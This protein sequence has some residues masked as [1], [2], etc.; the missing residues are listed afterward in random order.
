MAS[1][2]T[3]LS[4][5]MSMDTLS[6]VPLFG[7]VTNLHRLP[8]R[9]MRRAALLVTVAAQ[10]MLSHCTSKISTPSRSSPPKQIERRLKL[11]MRSKLVSLKLEV[12]ELAKRRRQNVLDQEKSLDQRKWRFLIEKE[13]FLIIKE[14]KIVLN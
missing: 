10:R 2:S 3:G 12:R 9:S 7:L 6:L 13:S 8:I 4:R 1:S 5:I 14:R 11:F